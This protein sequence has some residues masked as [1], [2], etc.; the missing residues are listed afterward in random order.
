LYAETD[1]SAEILAQARVLVVGCGALG[2]PA[3]LGLARGGVGHVTL[4]D[5]DVVELSNL[6][7]Q[8]LFDDDAIGRPKAEAAAATLAG[9]FRSCRLQP[10]VG[11]FEQSNAAELMRSHDFIIDATDD[12][13]SKFLINA[14]AT[15]VGRPM[16]YGGVVRTAGQAMGIDPG[17]SA[18]L[19]CAFPSREA[20]SELPEGCDRLGILSPVAGV[21]GFVQAL[22]AVRALTGDPAWRPGVL[23]IYQARGQRWRLVD[24]PRDPRCRCCSRLH[25]EQARRPEACH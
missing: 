24:F 22:S 15:E 23:T 5:A 21:I 10:L 1:N 16:S 4:L 13:A 9:M 17:R 7:R 6:Q 14:T 3:A 11:R 12:P 8:I 25:R 2:C 19:E 20:G 18:C